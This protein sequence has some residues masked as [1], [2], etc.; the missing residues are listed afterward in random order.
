MN[1]RNLLFEFKNKIIL[2]QGNYDFHYFS[3]IYSDISRLLIIRH[4]YRIYLLKM[5]DN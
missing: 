5:D 1:P 3:S 2:G 4:K